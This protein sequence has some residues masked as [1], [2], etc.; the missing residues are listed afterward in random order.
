MLVNP[1]DPDDAV[2]SAGLVGGAAVG[3]ALLLFGLA[4]AVVGLFLL[5]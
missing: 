3:P 5:R 2:V 4:A 1:E